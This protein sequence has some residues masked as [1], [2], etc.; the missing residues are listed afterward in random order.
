MHRY[1]L[2]IEYDGSQY[3]G[4]QRQRY[5]ISVQEILEGVL[6]GIADTPVSTVCAGRTDTGVHATA[7]VV[8]FDIPHERPE[9]A[10][11]LGANTKLPDSI[12]VTWAKEVD[13]AFHA[14][15]KAVARAYRYVIWNRASRPAIYAK[16]VTWVYQPLDASAM[17]EAAQVLV[18]RHDFSSF[19]AQGCQARHPT[20]ELHALTVRR[21]GHL[22]Y[23][24]IRANA[25]LHHMVRNIAGALIAVGTTEQSVDWIGELLQ[26]Q[27]R[28]HGGITAPPHGLY[29]SEV[30]YP[31]EFA[32]PAAPYRLELG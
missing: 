23:L 25:F 30:A 29:L 20:R 16:R 17:H 8:H 31:D 3:H 5:S 19:R 24:D 28:S 10:W 4:W 12:A 7:Q 26:L 21:S 15:F 11:T 13:P 2:G 22:I 9:R 27:D 1:A 32:I 6:T 18:G 14:R